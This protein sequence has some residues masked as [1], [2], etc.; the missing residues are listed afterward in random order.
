[1]GWTRQNCF[2]ANLTNLVKSVLAKFTGFVPYPTSA[3]FRIVAYSEGL[4][5]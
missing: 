1:M 2:G 5:F 3:Y 4:E